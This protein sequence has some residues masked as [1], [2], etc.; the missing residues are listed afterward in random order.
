M[1]PFDRK[2]IDLSLMGE[3]DT[4]LLDS[5]HAEILHQIGPHLPTDAKNWLQTACAPLN[6][7]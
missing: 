4:A 5:Y 7:A 2:L 3:A 6:K 1:A